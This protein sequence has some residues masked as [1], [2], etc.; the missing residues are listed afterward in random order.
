MP[1][2]LFPTPLPTAPPTPN[3][4]ASPTAHPTVRPTAAP[5]S[6][7][8]RHPTGIPTPVPTLGP[9]NH[10]TT[11]P[12]PN[13][14]S[15]PTG[16]PTAKPSQNPTNGP[17]LAPT[18]APSSKP[19]VTPVASPTFPPSRVPTAK[20]TVPPT[21]G[22]TSLGDIISNKCLFRLLPE[23]SECIDV[24]S[25]AD[26]KLAVESG[27]NTVT[28][29]GGF[30]LQKLGVAAVDV[31]SSVDIRCIEQCSFLGSGPFLNIGGMSSKIRLQN[32]RFA[33]SEDSSAIMISTMNAASQTTICDTEFERNHISIDNNDLG[34]AITVTR[35]SGVVNI[36]N[37]TFTANVASRGGAINS[38]G[39][40][41]NIV[42][43]KF[44]ANNAYET[45]NAIFVGNGKY[46]SVYS[47]TFLLNTEVIS[48]LNGREK[49]G[50]S[51]A[52]V[53][54]PNTALRSAA[55]QG[56]FVDYGKNSVALSGL[57]GGTLF[58]S[59]G[60]CQEFQ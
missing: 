3:P 56:T 24:S 9:T 51:F 34:G 53:V 25:F 20:P 48:R 59:T 10:P 13:P 17:T 2:T 12:I 15:P 30:S 49:P 52:I 19:T 5:S 43:S 46:L 29:C 55:Q 36:V 50:E 41:L 47:S 35:G 58:W 11:Q 60:K 40:K 1:P 8:T 38:E 33:N 22:P 4:T 16:I 39:F 31:S 44:V 28:F 7:P 21:Q 18:N 57:C 37:N 26:F 54:E 42:G 45:G 27:G 14:T 6:D 23:G 32:M